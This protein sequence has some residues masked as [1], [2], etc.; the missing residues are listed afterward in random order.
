M[1][2]ATRPYPKPAQ[3]LAPPFS[4]HSV[5]LCSH[6]PLAPDDDDDDD[7][8][9][10]GDD[11]DDDDDNMPQ[12]VMVMNMYDGDIHDGG[13]VA[14]H[15]GDHDHGSRRVVDSNLPILWVRL[16]ANAKSRPR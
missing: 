8:D 10:D 13:G 1:T 3:R 12:M 5:S 14:A 9:G 2:S 16:D 15:D 7:G 6:R 4:P 11:D